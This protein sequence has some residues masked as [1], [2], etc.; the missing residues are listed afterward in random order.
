[1]TQFLKFALLSA[2]ALSIST[3]LAFANFELNILHINDLHSRIEQINKYDSTCTAEESANNEC[4]GGIARVKAA[5]DARKSELG[6]DANIV[7]LDAGDQFQGSLFYTEYKS[8]PVAEFMNQMGFDA[9][10]VGNHEFDDGPEELL[11]LIDAA[12]FP[13]ISGN[14]MASD[15]SVLKDKIK[16][17]VIKEF[18]AEKVAIL[19][20]LAT[21]T[22]ETSSPGDK[23]LF[24]DE[25]SYLRDA[26]AE[27]KEQGINKILL[28]SHVGYYRDQQIA[29]TVDGIDV[30]IGGHSHTLLSN[31][32]DKALGPYPTLVKN[33]SG[34]DVPIVTAYAYSKYLGELKVT[35]D[36][37]GDVTS[38]SGAPLLLD[39]SVTPN[40]QF[41]ARIAELAKP[42]EEIRKK[43][44]GTVTA[45]VDGTREICRTQECTMGNLVADATL[46]RVKNQGMSIAI[47]G[48]GNLRASFKAG[49]VTMGDVLTVL[50]FQNSIA[51]MQL[52]GSAIRDAL[53]NGASKVEEVAGRFA[54]VSGLRYS[55][56]PARPAGQ[57]ILDIEVKQGDSFAPLDDKA[58]Y[59]VV[60]NNYMRAG[61]D[62]YDVF[63][64][65]ALNPYDFGPGLEEAV[66]A[67]LAE[68]SPY[69]P[70]LD[71]RIK[72]VSSAAA[73]T[74]S[75]NLSTTAPATTTHQGT[76]GNYIVKRGDSLWK[77]AQKTYG[78][79][80]QWSTIAKE[81]NLRRPN[82]IVPGQE[83][84]LPQR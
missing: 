79:G 3:S 27:V 69:T 84:T 19:S 15:S 11:K 29:A 74:S 71:G 16:P 44:V 36:D 12:K 48:G 58:T 35:F 77:I 34:K 20:V 7:V 37:N 60:T 32:E 80:H 24:A 63:V 21:D 31:T 83:L 1:M 28:L 62:G 30:I 45:D 54:Q 2:S 17:Y 57:R 51:T 39:N 53:E 33:P 75:S 25:I 56:D 43:E 22:D 13:I 50:P 41:A 23:I 47:L 26:V 6:A 10:A 5:I 46:D 72:V 65:K 55:V 9:M 8:G 49:S 76:T 68:N 82:V 61:G 70:K 64:T 81:N 18:G 59:G 73:Q 14:T 67:Y 52:K 38:A 78:D 66:A 40:A 4:F 42:L